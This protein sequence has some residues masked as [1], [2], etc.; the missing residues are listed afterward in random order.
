MQTGDQPG[1]L[2]NLGQSA[3]QK[4][5]LS[6]GFFGLFIITIIL[7]GAGAPGGWSFGYGVFHLIF[8]FIFVSIGLFYGIKSRQLKKQL[9]LK[10]HLSLFGIILNGL[11]FILLLVFAVIPIGLAILGSMAMK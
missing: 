8:G 10:S 9:N 6:L 5:W 7:L 11:I 1:S 3:N 4:G 2:P